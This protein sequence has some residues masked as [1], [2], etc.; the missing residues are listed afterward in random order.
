MEI[1]EHLNAIAALWKP[2]VKLTLLV[3]NEGHTGEQGDRDA[4]FTNDNLAEAIEAI[5][6]R[7]E[8]GKD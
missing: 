3:R 7:M 2:G 1:Q 8:V 6:L 5:R 4:V